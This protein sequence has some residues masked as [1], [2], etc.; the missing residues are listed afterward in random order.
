MCKE[1]YNARG[2][3]KYI[4]RSVMDALVRAEFHLVSTDFVL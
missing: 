4:M 1:V 3:Q 2:A